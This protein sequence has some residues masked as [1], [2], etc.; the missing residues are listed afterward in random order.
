MYD[1][2]DGG[3]PDDRP[4]VPFGVRLRELAALLSSLATHDRTA[5]SGEFETDRSTVAYRYSVET[6][7]GDRPADGYGRPTEPPEARRRVEANIP[8]VVD[9]DG[10]TVTVIAD[11]ADYDANDLLVGLEDDDVVILADGRVVDRIR[12][13][14]PDDRTTEARLNNGIL[15]FRIRP[16]ESDDDE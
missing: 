10:E 15:V 5:G 13:D 12:A 16:D 7:L 3:R 11:V 4:A 2:D 1:A 8:S 14:P 6:G 9:R